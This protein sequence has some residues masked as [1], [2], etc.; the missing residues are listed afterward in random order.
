MIPPWYITN[1][2]LKQQYAERIQ[3]AHD[4]CNEAR[5]T[6]NLCLLRQGKEQMRFALKM[7]TLRVEELHRLM[8]A[9][10]VPAIPI[11][12]DRELDTCHERVYGKRV[13]LFP[14]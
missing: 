5:S 14:L 2:R 13:E 1:Y 12:W 4:L 3:R 6:A 11:E 8:R 10:D 9:Y 7:E